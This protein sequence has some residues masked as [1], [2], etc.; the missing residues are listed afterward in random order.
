MVDVNAKI[1]PDNTGYKPFMGNLV[2]DEGMKI[3]KDYQIYKH[4][5]S[6]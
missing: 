5:I 3:E 4:K 2:L 6:L 1:G